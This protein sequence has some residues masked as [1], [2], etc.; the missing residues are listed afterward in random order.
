MNENSIEALVI[1][2]CEE[3]EELIIALKDQ[4][5]SHRELLDELMNT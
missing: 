2:L 1:S 3:L 4:C 5:N